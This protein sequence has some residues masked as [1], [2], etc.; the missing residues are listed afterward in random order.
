MRGFGISVVL[1][2]SFL[3]LVQTGCAF[4]QTPDAKGQADQADA[5]RAAPNAPR[6]TPEVQSDPAA[7]G[8]QADICRELVAFIQKTAADNAKP[9]PATNAATPAPVT[10]PAGG[11]KNASPDT[12]Q[13][14]SG[15]S[16]P[17]PKDDTVSAPP[18]LSLEQ[19][20]SLAAAHD[21]RGCQRAAQQMRRAGVALPPGVLALAALREDLLSAPK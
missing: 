13:R 9:N 11:M 10:P 12:S 3:C 8:G 2:A 21:L 15:V 18:K 4:A 5:L 16:G 17:V 1:C 14:Q 19:A 6:T 20:Q 7:G